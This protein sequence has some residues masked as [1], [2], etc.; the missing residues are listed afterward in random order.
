MT[1][2][3][4][5]DNQ[6]SV[7]SINVSSALSRRRRSRAGNRRLLGG[8]ARRLK[9]CAARNWRGTASGRSASLSARWQI[10]RFVVTPILLPAAVIHRRSRN[11]RSLFARVAERGEGRGAS[12]PGRACRRC[13]GRPQRDRAMRASGASS[14]RRDGAEA[15]GVQRASAVLRPD[16]LP[17]V[18][19]MCPADWDRQNPKITLT[20]PIE[21]TVSGS[22]GLDWDRGVP[23]SG[24]LRRLFRTASSLD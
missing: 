19:Y 9:P 11:E 7:F 15:G 14:E 3:R 22:A 24:Q 1:A 5:A 10:S 13:T 2:T 20:V 16:P 23:L 8:A 18:Y 17:L 21:G 4:S 6:A 12:Q